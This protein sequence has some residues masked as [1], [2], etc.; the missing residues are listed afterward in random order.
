MV[1]SRERRGNNNCLRS[2]R[3]KL[4]HESHQLSH[5]ESGKRRTNVILFIMLKTNKQT[6]KQKNLE[7]REDENETNTRKIMK[8]I[9]EI[10]CWSWE[11]PYTWYRQNQY[12]A[13]KR[14]NYYRFYTRIIAFPQKVPQNNFENFEI[15]EQTRKIQNTCQYLL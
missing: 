2:K 13:W 4:S 3:R 12:H 7:T 15:E 10:K 9:T 1:H 14:W 6:N 5:W 8:T 11:D